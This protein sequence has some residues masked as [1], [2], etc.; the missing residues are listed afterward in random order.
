MRAAF[1]G[2]VTAVVGGAW[3]IALGAIKAYR[4]D[5]AAGFDFAAAAAAFFQPTTVGGWTQLVAI[6]VV[7]LGGGLATGAL[8]TARHGGERAAAEARG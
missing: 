7:A 3:M 1:G 8:Y 4:A 5:A 6:V 2:L